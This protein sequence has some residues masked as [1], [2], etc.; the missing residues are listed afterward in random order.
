MAGWVAAASALG[1][2]V[3]AAESPVVRAGSELDFRPYGFT[4]KD[5]QP[6]GFG[7]ELLRSVADKMGLRLE[8]TVGPW[9]TVWNE[10]VAGKLDV[11]P[12]VARTPGR[13]P[14]VDFSLPHT[15]TFDAF[16]VRSGQPVIASVAA[17]SGKEIVV[18]REDAAHHELLE[19]KFAGKIIAVGSI[20]EGLRLVAA[21]KHDAFLCSKVIGMLELKA[22][23]IAGVAA[24]PP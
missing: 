18:L 1:S 11:L 13:E 4:D 23:K 24:G 17:A 5:G 9:D 15:E 7:P 19:R 10:L 21:G 20:S 6:T 12:V 16:F 22:A 3:L 8:R 2:P 14:L